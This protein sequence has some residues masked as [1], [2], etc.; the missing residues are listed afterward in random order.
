[1]VRFSRGRPATRD[2][3]LVSQPRVA[4]ASISGM[5]V[6]RS[7][8]APREWT[9]GPVSMP[10]PTR[11]PIRDLMRAASTW[12]GR[13]YLPEASRD[14]TGRREPAHS[15]SGGADAGM[16]TEAGC[17]CVC[18]PPGFLRDAWNAPRFTSRNTTANDTHQAQ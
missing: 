7:I 4:A 16:V 11:L 1:M 14:V 9:S 5:S 18:C 17:Q 10:P 2:R 15:S 8:S 12:R 3:P 13:P 6:R